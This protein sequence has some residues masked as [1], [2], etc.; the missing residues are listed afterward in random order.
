MSNYV[1][2]IFKKKTAEDF[3]VAAEETAAWLDTLSVKSEHGKY[4]KGFPEGQ[5]GYTTDIP[6][7]TERCYYNGAAGIGIFFVRLYL[8]TGEEKWLKEAEEAA[9]YLMSSELGVDWYEKL[10]SAKDIGGIIPV[11]GWAMGWSNGPVGEA[12][13]MLDLYDAT[14]KKEYFDFAVRQA[15]TLIKAA[16][17]EGEYIKWSDEQDLCA[18]GGHITFLEIIYRRTGEK[19]Y[20]D[21]AVKAA[22]YIAADYTESKYGG[23][24]WRLLDLSKIDFAPDTTF[25]NFAHGTSG[26]GWMFANLYN[27]TKDE[28]FLN[29]AK[30]AAVYLMNISVGDETGRLIPYQDHPVTGLTYEHYYLSDCHGPVG[31]VRI[32]QKLYEITNDKKYYDFAVELSRGIIKAGAPAELSWGYWNCHCLCCGTAGILEH[33][34]EMYKFTKSEEFLKYAELT[35]KVML[36]KSDDRVQGIRNWND[37]WW[38][39]NP[40]RIVSYTGFYVGSA[41]MAASL[42]YY[43]GAK[44]EKKLNPIFVNT[45]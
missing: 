20:L 5:N 24:F 30:D 18:D 17:P 40:N 2:G 35:A 29:L 3:L 23:K 16:V 11:P 1:P 8:A 7:F 41:G 32:F 12:Y 37:G 14:N 21:A 33:F 4:W 38:R 22:N 42:L 25:P 9:S 39:T 34:V 45:L 43:Y 44:K 31:S 27:D 15:D 26:I 10:R 36:S 28:K 13:F 19:K 6:M